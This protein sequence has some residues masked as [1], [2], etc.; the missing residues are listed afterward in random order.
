[1]F[2]EPVIGKTMKLVEIYELL[3]LKMKPKGSRAT[4]HSKPTWS[5]V[6][7][8][9]LSLKFSVE[10]EVLFQLCDPMK[11][12]FSAWTSFSQ[13]KTEIFIPTPSLS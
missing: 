6:S 13:Q 7:F 3:L 9:E 5:I 4:V 11:A 10:I 8:T 1:M 12:D 2:T